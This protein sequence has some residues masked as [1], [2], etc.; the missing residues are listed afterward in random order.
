[1]MRPQFFHYFKASCISCRG[2]CVLYVHVS[3]FCWK[4]CQNNPVL[5]L[6]QLWLNPETGASVIVFLQ[7]LFLLFYFHLQSAWGFSS[8][9]KYN[10]LFLF[11]L[12]PAAD[13]PAR[14]CLYHDSRCSFWQALCQPQA[15]A[16]LVAFVHIQLQI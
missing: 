6:Y 8:G 5:L 16:V 13:R 11:F 4:C 2:G 15:V 10:L 9:C 3:F 7:K 14:L 12:F 1:M